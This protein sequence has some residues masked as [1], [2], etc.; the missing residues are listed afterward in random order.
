MFLGSRFAGMS[1][2]TWGPGYSN[3]P[4][5]LGNYVY[6]IS[7]D[8][9][10]ETGDN[11]YIARVHRD[12]ILNRLAWS[13]Y[14]GTPQMPAWTKNENM[15]KP[16]FSDTGHVGHPTLM[17]NKPLGRYFMMI[18]SDTIPHHENATKAERAK[19]DYAS[20]LQI[21]EAPTPFGPWALVYNE[22]P[23]GGSDHSCYLGQMPAL[24]LAPDGLSGYIMF[25]GD[26]INRKGEY[27]GLMTQKYSIKIAPQNK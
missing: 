8:G 25:A 19:W 9:S 18:Y 4:A 24:W 12:S 17:Y 11:V 27:Y 26:Y 13:F 22:M 10:W 5:E 2:I 1:F 23:W 6:G 16:I 20:E 14:N 7:N 3:V 21:Y 15:A